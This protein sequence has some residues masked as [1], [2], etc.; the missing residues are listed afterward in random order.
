MSSSY[1]ATKNW[2]RS[3]FKY[4]ILASVLG[5][6]LSR[7][8]RKWVLPHGPP[9]DVPMNER[10]VYSS[11]DFDN[12]SL[13]L[14]HGK[15]QKIFERREEGRKPLMIGPETVVVGN[16]GEI[17]VLTEEAKLVQLTNLET[18]ADGVT[19]MATAVEVMNLGMGRPLGG[20]FTP[21][22]TLYIADT[23]LGLI[24]VKNPQDPRAKVELV[25]SRVKVDGQWSQIHYCND[26]KVGPK[27]GKVYFSDATEL[28]P[29]RTGTRTWDSLYTSK[30]DLIRG[31]RTGRVLE[32]DPAT[33]EVKVLMDDLWFAN[34][35]GVDK[36]ETYIV[37]SET[38]QSRVLKYSLTNGSTFVAVDKLTGY[39]D[40]H[41][42]SHE[43]GL[44]YVPVPSAALPVMKLIYAIPSP[45]DRFFRVLLL[46]LPRS[47]SPQIVAYGA[48]YE[49]FPGDETKPGG[50]TRLL[51]DP[52]GKDISLLTGVTVNG[53]KLYLGSL[54]NKFIGVYDLK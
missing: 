12:D 6:N 16:Q 41:D 46:L 35:I 17:F 21:D 37:V 15:L 18:Q 40:G 36:D 7:L 27:T 30:V 44:C 38:F 8:I 34:G 32:Y 49:Y 48:V 14:K 54:R 2:P 25:A 20:A 22:G 45:F 19:V 43:T 50:I 52:E 42:C 33:D 31:R 10:P 11:I 4:I 24:R 47:L 39:P 53:S 23:L 26:L 9:V 1:T 5:F 28:S 13:R 29:D 3:T 51:Q